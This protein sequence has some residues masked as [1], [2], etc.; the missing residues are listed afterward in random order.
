MRFYIDELHL[1]NHVTCYK[2]WKIDLFYFTLHWHFLIKMDLSFKPALYKDQHL[3]FF[4]SHL[5]FP[6]THTLLYICLFPHPSSHTSHLQLR[7][8]WSA[9]GT[10]R[11]VSWPTAPSDWRGARPRATSPAIAS[12]WPPSPPGG[13]TSRC[14]RDRWGTPGLH[15]WELMT[16]PFAVGQSIDAVELRLLK[17]SLYPEVQTLKWL[18]F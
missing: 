14:S 7:S 15:N 5:H 3:H 16:W 2:I 12:W 4:F 1:I 6:L 17:L 9:P 18:F 13:S 11:S 8:V 10:C